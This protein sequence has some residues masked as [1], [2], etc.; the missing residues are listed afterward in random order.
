MRAR[1]SVVPTQRSKPR[2]I[3]R[4][5]YVTAQTYN[6][7]RR[8]IFSV[9][10]DPHRGF[11]VANE[12]LDKTYQKKLGP[13]CYAGLKA[14]LRFYEDYRSEFRLTVA[15]DM[16]EHADFSGLFGR[17]ITRF[18]V[19][20]NLAYKSF[21]DYEPFLGDGIKY[22]VALL[23]HANFN[24]IDVFDL[25]FKKCERCDGNG[26][27]IPFI[28][29]CDQNYNRHGESQWTN[30]QALMEVCTNCS[31]YGERDRFTSTFIQSPRE[32]ADDIYASFD[33]EDA[34]EIL[35]SYV[36]DQYKY[37]RREFDDN[38]MAVASHSYI[39]TDRDGDGY[40]AINFN[41]KNKAVAESLPD[42]IETDVEI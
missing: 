18:D 40:W 8:I 12:Y 9:A 17:D 22:K 16:G 23:D 11:A 42:D 31:D 4:R 5:C 15:G 41:F 13:R 39:M 32:M 7:I 19:T 3:V 20:T 34:G 6:E 37:F 26:Y 28:L 10:N 36:L 35:D 30:D 21:G 24:V 33:D 27:L 38:L 25:A 14:E 1:L 2:K 29:L